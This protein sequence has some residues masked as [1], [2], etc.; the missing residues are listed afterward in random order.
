MYH[1]TAINRDAEGRHCPWGTPRVSNVVGGGSE[2]SCAILAKALGGRELRTRLQRRV[3][4]AWVAEQQP[5][6]GLSVV[7]HE[8]LPA[9]HPAHRQVHNFDDVLWSLG[10]GQRLTEVADTASAIRA[11]ARTGENYGVPRPRTR[12]S[13][14]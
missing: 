11:I 2:A 9:G 5:I 14:P 7:A 4:G 6:S 1:H 3:A 13:T 8:R 12:S 10:V